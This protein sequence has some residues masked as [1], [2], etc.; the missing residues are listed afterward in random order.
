MINA[1]RDGDTT[2]SA[3]ARL[4]RDVLDEDPLMVIVLLGGNDALNRVPRDETMNNI[5]R[6]VGR[7]VD[8]GAMVVLVHAKYGVFKDPYRGD[9]KRI[10]KKH[11]AV[12]MPN[13]LN[14]IFGNPRAMSDQIHPNNT[15]YAVVASRIAQVVEPLLLQAPDQ[16]ES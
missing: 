16:T 13:V 12:F 11:G 5:D 15:G 7:C 2:G 8:A 3:L 14:D 4:Q 1:G 6:L 9:F 10:A